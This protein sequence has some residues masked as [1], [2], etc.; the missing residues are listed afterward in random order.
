MKKIIFITLCVGACLWICKT[1]SWGAEVKGNNHNWTFIGSVN[2]NSVIRIHASGKVDFG[3]SFGTCNDD[4]FAGVTGKSEEFMKLFNSFKSEIEVARRNVT[5]PIQLTSKTLGV[6]AKYFSNSH[7][8]NYEQ[9]GV[10]IKILKRNNVPYIGTQLYYYWAVQGGIN[11]YG[12]PINEDVNVYAKAHDGG[13]NPE[14]T[15]G[16]GDN[17]GSYNVTIETV[18]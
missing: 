7:E 4:A 5:D 1:Y 16:Y 15:K 3:C 8:P 14:A 11:E 6:I 2:K 13:K 18:H 9:G 17:K 12:L 10:W